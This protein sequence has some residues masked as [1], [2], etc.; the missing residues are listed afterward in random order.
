MRLLITFC[1]QVQV[2][3]T[4]GMAGGT[5]LGWTV[6]DTSSARMEKVVSRIG[7]PWNYENPRVF[8]RPKSYGGRTELSYIQWRVREFIHSCSLRTS[9]VWGWQ[10]HCSIDYVEVKACTIE[11][12]EHPQIRAFGW[13][14][15]VTINK[16][17]L[18][19]TQDTYKWSDLFCLRAD[20]SYFLCYTRKRD[21]C[22]TPSLIV[23]QRPAG[24]PRSW[25]HAV[26]GWHTVR[27]VWLNADWLLSNVVW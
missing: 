25:E 6:A 9:C 3:D 2:V 5:G 24:F 11:S 8:E 23:F 20:V 13:T 19:C 15:W 16:T 10:H 4:K 22:V 26:I 12:S 21:V 7:R 14:H 27:I 1:N 18:L 17:S